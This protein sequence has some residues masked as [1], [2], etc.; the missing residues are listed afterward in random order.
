[1]ARKFAICGCQ[2]GHIE[3]AAQELIAEGWELAEV[4]D[5]DPWL[6]KTVAEKHGGTLVDD[7]RAVLGSSDAELIAAAPINREK[8]ELIEAA[9]RSGRHVIA[10]KPLV[11]TREDLD[12]AAQAAEETGKR[13]IC[14]FTSRYSGA[15]RAVRTAV[16]EGAIGK[17]VGYIGLGPHRLGPKDRP[18]WMFDDAAY[19]GVLV[20][21]AC[22][23]VDVFLWVS[24]EAMRE[25]TAYEAQ[26]R[27]AGLGHAIHDVGSALFVTTAGATAFCRGDWLTPDAYPGH[28]D[29]RMVFTGTAGQVEN[30][31]NGMPLEAGEALVVSY[32]DGAAP[33]RLAPEKVERSLAGEFV[34]YAFHGGRTHLTTEECLASMRAIIL[35]RES[36]K[37]GRTISFD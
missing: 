13:V 25:V 20:D 32:S 33:E 11:V 2:H 16:Q 5:A 8:G 15:V 31:Q 4:A 29:Y 27:W 18:P 6:A 36:A 24:G 7:W 9:L 35:A 19:G 1:M 23:W 37:A 26:S 28:G 3:S 17:V 30:F 14:M 10:D 34:D 12:R 21:I 22:H